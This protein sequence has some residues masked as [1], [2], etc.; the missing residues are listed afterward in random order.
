MKCCPPAIR[1]N[2]RRREGSEVIVIGVDAH[3]DTHTV[4]AVEEGTGR[5]LGELTAEARE[6]GFVQAAAVRRA[7]H[8]RGAGVGGRGLPARVRRLGAVPAQ[9]GGDGDP[10][11]AEAD[12]QR[13]PRRADV[14]QVGLDRRARGRARV[15]ARAR[16]AASPV[17]RPG[18]RDRVAD[19]LS[20]RPGR[21]VTPAAEPGAV[22]AARPRSRAGARRSRAAQRGRAASARR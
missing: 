7:P 14:R 11:A 3:K 16:A 9:S 17:G 1:P 5:L 4:V 19:R 13:A 20:R 10:G 2:Q 12:G 6:H 8:R 18:A 22:A 21:R 15:A